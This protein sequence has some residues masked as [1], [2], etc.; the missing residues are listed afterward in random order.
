SGAE[1]NLCLLADVTAEFLHEDFDFRQCEPGPTRHLHKNVC[2]ICKHPATIHQRILERLRESVMRAIA[3]IGF[4][5]AKQATAVVSA[6][7]R[8]QII[9]ADANESRPLDQV[10]N[11]ANTLADRDISR[12]EGLMNSSVWRDHVAH[13]IVLEANH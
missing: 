12:C 10:N 1:E 7:C 5:V 2:G 9:E 8:K 13:S 4:A 6:Q 11:R 3:R